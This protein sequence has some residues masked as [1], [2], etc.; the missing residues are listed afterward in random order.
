MVFCKTVRH[1]S[2]DVMVI[3]ASDTQEKE[4]PLTH[5]GGVGGGGVGGG[6][7]QPA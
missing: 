1:R 3:S 2:F 4:A 7:L 5:W 6:G